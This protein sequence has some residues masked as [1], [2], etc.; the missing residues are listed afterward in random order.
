MLRLH[1]RG[2][3]L[4]ELMVAAVIGIIGSII[5]FQVFSVF[6]G[7]KRGT[8]S[9][10]DAETNVAIATSAIEQ[11][12]RGAGYGLHFPSHLGC[13]VYQWRHPAGPP[14]VA[15]TGTFSKMILAPILLERHANSDPKLRGL[16]SITFVRTR[17]DTT[18]ATT[19]LKQEMTDAD[20]GSDSPI[21]VR[22]MYGFGKGDILLIAEKRD[23]GANASKITCA[24]TDILDLPLPNPNPT[25]PYVNT[26]PE[27]IVH[28][29]GE[30][31]LPG[32]PN[33]PCPGPTGDKC[34]TVY[35]KIPGTAPIGGL[36]TLDTVTT[37]NPT[38][39]IAPTP[40][41]THP[42]VPDAPTRFKFTTKAT[43][44]NVGPYVKGGF[45][46]LD[47]K[48]FALSNGQLV[49]G[50]PT[51]S[52]PVPLV[53]G[54]VFMDAQLGMAASPTRT[55]SETTVTY[56][57]EMPSQAPVEPN[58]TQE[59][60]FK[61]RTVRIVMIV[62]GSQYD[63]NYTSPSCFAVWSTATTV[64]CTAPSTSDPLKVVYN[65]PSTDV[66]YRH[67][68]VELVIPLRNFYWRPM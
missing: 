45:W 1:Q 44:M 19:E 32:I 49:E 29:R 54:V 41:D 3:S 13:T 14:P 61:L 2:F 17:G 21:K 27:K 9:S 62:R 48:Q 59:D 20:G 56:V 50:D 46:A 66:G 18:Y 55:S 6:E 31:F 12:A 33:S 30:F 39:T 63:K 16:K 53:D 23:T 52:T 64:D 57:R 24:V 67:K 34:Y 43:V 4:V 38:P 51:V 22:N 36:A 11:A 28:T 26:V 15:P 35:N 58:V 10:G 37:D 65:V 40:P 7:Q 68:V 42:Q 60:W 5:I 25:T 47:R 8:T